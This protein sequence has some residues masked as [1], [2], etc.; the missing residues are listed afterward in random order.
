MEHLL[1]VHLLMVHLLM[2]VDHCGGL[3]IAHTTLIM[4]CSG[5]TVTFL[6]S[7]WLSSLGT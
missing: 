5:S 1:M 7:W 3:F 2:V 4:L 6:L